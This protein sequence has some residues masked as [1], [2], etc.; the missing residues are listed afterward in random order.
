LQALP[1]RSW[2]QDITGGLTVEAIIEYLNLWDRLE[3]VQLHPDQ[4][5]VVQWT[6]SRTVDTA[7]D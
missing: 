4:E 5:D 1:D 2:V 7:R 3:G 6:G